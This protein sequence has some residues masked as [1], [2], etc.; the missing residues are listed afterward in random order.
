[1][2][3][4]AAFTTIIL[5]AA[6]CFAV[7][8][9]RALSVPLSSDIAWQLHIAEV[10]A[11]GG[12]L[13]RD[14]IEVNPPLAAWLEV[15]VVRLAGAF[16]VGAALG[17]EIAVLL[18]GLVSVGLVALA[19][20]RTMVLRAPARLVAFTLATALALALQAGLEVGQREQLAIMLVLP[21]FVLL[22]VR[23]EGATVPPWLAA[24]IGMS[25][26]L[27]FA[28]KP[29]FLLPLL[30]GEV[31]VVR[32]RGPRAAVR[33]PELVALA[34][35]FVAY[36]LAILV[37]A[38]GWLVSARAFWPL[39]GAYRPATLYD[40]VTRQGVVIVIAALALAAWAVARR[41]VGTSSQLGNALAAALAGFLVAMLAQ[42]KPWIYLAIPSGVL[43]LALLVTIVLETSGRV[44]SR[45]GRLARAILVLATALRVARYAWW[46][47]HAPVL[48]VT[49]RTSLTDYTG[50]RAVLDSLP[51]GV[52]MAALSP[53]H[54][55]TFPLVQDVGATWTMRLPSLWPAISGA[56]QDDA[57][58]DALRRL[59][60]EDLER[61]H[62]DVLL[63]LTPRTTYRWLGPAAMRDWRAWLA[64]SPAGAT[65]L[66]PYREWRTV[67]EF[68]VWRREPGS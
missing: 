13:G 58:Q 62:P 60:T 3:R 43:S 9:A 55:I 19:G 30:M 34:T 40:V 67:G 1:M 45:A 10:L 56:A 53:T 39:Y 4:G 49:D 18:L 2:S 21:H 36:A 66:A 51:T 29:F 57:H 46:V 65:A 22:A 48:S 27:G 5:G 24:V 16:G 31:L 61:F 28:L 54:G 25:A 6:L 32:G 52:T 47:V 37:I 41:T 26:G 17:H 63:V 68:S 14:V 35:V 8:L 42:R 64:Q 11:R 20:E 33:R 38:P 7:A 44:R 15:P 50:L 59:V 12:Q 23:L